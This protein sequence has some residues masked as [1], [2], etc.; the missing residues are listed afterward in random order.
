MLALVFVVTGSYVSRLPLRGQYQESV[1]LTIVC[2]TSGNVVTDLYLQL[3]E[4]ITVLVKVVTTSSEPGQ[5]LVVS[6]F[7]SAPSLLV[8]VPRDL[9]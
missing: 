4:A 1:L 2:R 6:V 3:A 7:A 5:D 8:A 9:T